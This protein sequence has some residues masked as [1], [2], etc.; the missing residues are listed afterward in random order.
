MNASPGITKTYLVEAAVTQYAAVVVGANADGNCKLPAAA[1][2]AGFLGF[3]LEG[4]SNVGKGIAVQK[5]GIA[6]AVANGTITRGDRLII[7]S[8]T[9]DV[10]SAETEIAAGLENPAKELNVVGRAEESA[11]NGQTFAVWVTPETVP[12]AVS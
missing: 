12:L 7:A 4:Q 5:N 9:G 2:A 11:V 10:K 1:N 8:N 6:R 3:T